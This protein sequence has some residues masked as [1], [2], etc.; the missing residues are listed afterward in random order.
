MENDRSLKKIQLSLAHLP[1][2]ML[3]IG[4]PLFWFEMLA[5]SHSR[6]QTTPLAW[7]V[8]LGMSMA[9]IVIK[10]KGAAIEAGAWKPFWGSLGLLSR[11]WVILASLLVILILLVGAY[12]AFLPPHL[13]QEE[14]ALQYHITLARQ[15]LLLHSFAHIPWTTADLF[16]LPVQFALAPFWLATNLPNKIPQFI[17]FLGLVFVCLNLVRMSASN[18]FWGSLLFIAAFA[19]SQ[20][21]TIQMGTAMV[22]LILAY[23][24][25]ASLDS[26][27]TGRWILATIEFAFFF[28]SKSFVPPQMVML[29]AITAV[30]ILF[31]KKMG[32]KQVTL[33]SGMP[34]SAEQ[35]QVLKKNLRKG[36][37]L[38][39]VLSGLIGG[40]FII[41]S[42]YYSGTPLY[43][44]APGLIKASHFVGDDSVKWRSLL[45][46]AD[47]YMASKDAYG[48]GRSPVDF[49]K[50]LW[51]VAVPES[52]VNNSFDY[53]LGLPYLLFGG[54]FLAVLWQGFKNREFS[55][56]AVAVCVFWILWWFGS[57]QSRFLFIPFIFMLI[58]VAAFLKIPS[59]ILL[60]CLLLAL[61]I[62]VV[63][64]YRAHRDDLFKP[65]T[66][67]LREKDKKL[68]QMNEEY[69]SGSMSG[70][71]ELD[72][73]DAAFAQFPVDVNREKMPFVVLY[74]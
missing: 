70:P 7:L 23:L 46:S 11:S 20:G 25:L 44:F 51:L 40:P 22:D 15:H 59:R 8:F 32:G 49:M 63:S 54:G 12:A 48:H 1:T 47:A 21:F 6:G 30:F 13:I 45:K 24:F 34:L 10:W 66:Q 56:V 65:V 38:F 52:G 72:Y 26:L 73:P 42:L 27:L 71:V 14:D 39:L 33:F 31:F 36:G 18:V 58:T 43:P 4:Y 28:Y 50:H 67:I 60:G 19:G 16:L 37:I 68:L 69:F 17:F 2:L 62:N 3:I 35:W 41:K 64:V 74:K 61:L 53:P 5:G 55:L 29:F 9:L 57:Q